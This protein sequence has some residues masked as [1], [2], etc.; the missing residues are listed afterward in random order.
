[1][2]RPRAKQRLGIALEGPEP[3]PT[4]KRGRTMEH[5]SEVFIGLDTSKLKIYVA[6][7]DGEWLA[8]QLAVICGPHRFRQLALQQPPRS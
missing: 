5:H 6:V 8:W 4:L 2:A 3:S 1:M 7:A